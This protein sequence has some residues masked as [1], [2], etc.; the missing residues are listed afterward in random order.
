MPDTN[1][2]ANIPSATAAVAN[3]PTTENP[4][5]SSPPNDD[6]A[7][8]AA[9]DDADDAASAIAASIASS[10][11]SITDSIREYRL[12]NGRTYHKYKDGIYNLPNDDRENDRLDLQHNLVVR[13]FNG[14]L[15]TA[16]PND[17]DAKVGRVLDLGTG[18]G[19]WA[20]EFGD[21]HPE[22]EVIGVDL[23][24]A[25]P[26]FVPPNVRFE[27]DDVEEVWTYSRPFD[28][29][30]SRM[31]TS[32]ISNWK[33]YIKQA[34]DHLSPGGYLEL[35]EPDLKPLSDDGTLKEDSALMKSIGLIEEAARIFGRPYEDIQGLKDVMIET[36]FKDVHI[37]RF[38]WPTNGWA[39]DPKYRE[40]G[41]WNY[42]NFAA[43]WEAFTMAPFTRALAWTKEEVLIHAMEVRRDL[44]DR[45]IHAYFSLWS[46]WGRKPVGVDEAPEA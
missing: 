43:N 11:T 29:I 5:H 4:A 46:I 41:A 2:A 31:M 9:D 36:G 28:Y 1:Q 45:R 32:S 21:D 34:Y 7:F 39:K 24:A 19:I 23:S 10:T 6:N 3:S 15:G 27:V 44:A 42:E 18:S 30:H 13:S 26:E 12:E 38:K 33:A 16:P 25:Q 14:R 17:P 35:N 37:Q 20:M 22:A 40:I 8:I